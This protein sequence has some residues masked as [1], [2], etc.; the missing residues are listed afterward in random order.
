MPVALRN[1]RRVAGLELARRSLRYTLTRNGDQYRRVFSIIEYADDET[2]EIL[3]RTETETTLLCS[4][5]RSPSIEH[6]PVRNPA[7]QSR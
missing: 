1:H 2:G 7:H 4:G 6:F 3:L 5:K